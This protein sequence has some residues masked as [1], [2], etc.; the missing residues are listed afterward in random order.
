MFRTIHPHEFDDGTPSNSELARG[1]RLG[2]TKRFVNDRFRTRFMACRSPYPGEGFFCHVRIYTPDSVARRHQRTP[3]EGRFPATHVSASSQPDLVEPG[4]IC[5]VVSRGFLER[6]IMSI[7]SPLKSRKELIDQMCSR[8][9]SLASFREFDDLIIWPTG[10]WIHLWTPI[11]P[12]PRGQNRSRL[13]IPNQNVYQN[14]YM[15]NCP[16]PTLRMY[17]NPERLPNGS[18]IERCACGTWLIWLNKEVG[19]DP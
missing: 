1:I 11:K 10:A 5:F 16:D 12:A 9:S 15:H 18:R 13:I 2:W 17:Y 3:E 4:D 7:D 6:A 14:V 8:H 19:Q